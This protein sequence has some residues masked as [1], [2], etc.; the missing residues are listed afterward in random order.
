MPYVVKLKGSIKP[1]TYICENLRKILIP[2]RIMMS[3]TKNNDN[4]PNS[5]KQQNNMPNSVSKS[6]TRKLKIKDEYTYNFYTKFNQ[7]DLL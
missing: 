5:L 1:M 4:Q 6:T 2:P 7:T 3:G